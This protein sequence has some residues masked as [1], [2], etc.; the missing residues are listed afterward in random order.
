MDADEAQER[1]SRRRR[2]LLRFATETQDETARMT[3]DFDPADPVGRALEEI[4]ENCR[5]LIAMLESSTRRPQP[6]PSRDD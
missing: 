3:A 6:E 2:L 5:Q 1:L 4:G